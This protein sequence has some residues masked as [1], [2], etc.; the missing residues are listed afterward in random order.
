MILYL[1]LERKPDGTDE[2]KIGGGSSTPRRPKLYD[3][4]PR[5]KAYIKNRPNCRIKKIYTDTLP[6][7]S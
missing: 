6:E 3:S 2:Y 1:I 4:L 5:A 7:V